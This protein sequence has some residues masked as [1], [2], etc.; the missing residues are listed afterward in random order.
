M[1]ASFVG[2]LIGSIVFWSSFLFMNGEQ[3]T[4]GMIIGV[5]IIAIAAYQ[6]CSERPL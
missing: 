6:K 3:G 4:R 5:F 2:R 1:K